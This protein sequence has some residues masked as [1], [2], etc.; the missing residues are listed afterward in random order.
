MR[1]NKESKERITTKRYKREEEKVMKFG[2][3]YSEE[4]MSFDEFCKTMFNCK[5]P[6]KEQIRV[7]YLTKEKTMDRAMGF[8]EEARMQARMELKKKMEKYGCKFKHDGS[9]LNNRLC[10]VAHLLRIGRKD[11]AEKELK[12]VDAIFTKRRE[13]NITK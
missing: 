7:A 11:L 5:A 12:V 8:V 13:E 10:F 9:I 6:T 4:P 2:D 1:S 3:R